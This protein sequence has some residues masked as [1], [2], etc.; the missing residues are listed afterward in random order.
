M[1]QDLVAGPLDEGDLADKLR[2]D[3]LH[4]T[5]VLGGHCHS[6]RA[7]R[8]VQRLQPARQVGEGGLG[9]AGA[10]VPGVSQPGSIPG[11]DQQRADRVRAAALA[12]FPAA[13]DDFLVPDVLDL[14]PVPALA[15]NYADATPAS[16]TRR[17]ARPNP[18]L[19]PRPSAMSSP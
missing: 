11:A 2:V 13:D 5:G 7:V 3:P 12:G 6:E 16:T 4:A 8:T 17:C 18:S 10:D 1:T 9:E 15:P 14:D 19:L